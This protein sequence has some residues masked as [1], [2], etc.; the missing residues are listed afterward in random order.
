MNKATKNHKATGPAFQSGQVWYIEPIKKIG[1]V[2]IDR[3]EKEGN[4]R[5]LIDYRVHFTYPDGGKGSK[6]AWN[7]QIHY[8]HE[9]DAKIKSHK[10]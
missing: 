7:F 2:I 9:A 4:G 5:G 3:V 1:K 6:D 8:T 10:L